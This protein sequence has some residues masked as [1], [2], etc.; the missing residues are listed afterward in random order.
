[1]ASTTTGKVINF[2]AGPAKLPEQVSYRIIKVCHFIDFKA[3]GGG[4][5]G[6]MMFLGVFIRIKVCFPHGS[7]NP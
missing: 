4:S 2:A 5:R 7:T 1:M 6:R 3:G